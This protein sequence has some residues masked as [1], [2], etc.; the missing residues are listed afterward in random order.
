MPDS[1]PKTGRVK[2]KTREPQR[3]PLIVNAARSRVKKE[4]T[5]SAATARALRDYVRWAAAEASL[6][7]DEATILTLDKAVAE[8][9][10]KD[11]LWQAQSRETTDEAQVFPVPDLAR[12]S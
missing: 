12:K 5:M 10:R 9:L 6:T 4:I 2:K 11:E 1:A 7:E 8:L 3:R